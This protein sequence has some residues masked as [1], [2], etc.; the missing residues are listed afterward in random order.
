[1]SNKAFT[2]L[3]QNFHCKTSYIYVVSVLIIPLTYGNDLQ[4]IQLSLTFLAWLCGYFVPLLPVYIG[5]NIYRMFHLRSYL[6]CPIQFFYFH[7]CYILFIHIIKSNICRNWGTWMQ[8]IR[9]GVRSLWRKH[10]LVELLSHFLNK[11]LTFFLSWNQ[12]WDY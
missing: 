8:Y 11:S 9:S 4:N 2:F 10:S 5:H 7:T 12:F 1:M 3:Y 6:D